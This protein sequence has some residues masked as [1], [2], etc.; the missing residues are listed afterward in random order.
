MCAA[1]WGQRS[2]VKL[3]EFQSYTTKLLKSE[4][5]LAEN[6]RRSTQQHFITIPHAKTIRTYIKLQ[7]NVKTT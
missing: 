7:H 2:E 6:S 5:T 4:I 3:L 1:E